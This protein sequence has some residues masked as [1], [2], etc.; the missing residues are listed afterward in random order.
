MEWTC[1]E[2]QNVY[3]VINGIDVCKTKTRN[4]S[5]RLQ[6]DYFNLMFWMNG[7]IAKRKKI[8]TRNKKNRKQKSGN[9]IITKI[10]EL[11]DSCRRT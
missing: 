1:F 7:D 6:K 11:L 8:K 10:S 5:T 3:T 4:K 9:E 2:N